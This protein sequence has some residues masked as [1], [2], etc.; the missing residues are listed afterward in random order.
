MWHLPAT[1]NALPAE[2]KPQTVQNGDGEEYECRR[3]HISPLPHFHTLII[4]N[5]LLNAAYLPIGETNLDAA[6]VEFGAG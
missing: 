1:N 3:R 2:V 6:R 5:N 4:S